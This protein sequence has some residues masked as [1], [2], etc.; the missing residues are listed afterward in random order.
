[1]GSLKKENGRNIV[2]TYPKDNMELCKS[3][4]TEMKEIHNSKSSKAL[5][6]FIATAAY[7]SPYANEV[8]ILRKYRDNVLLKTF[9]GRIMVSTY[10]LVSPPVAKIIS[11][12]ETLKSA[13]RRYIIRPVLKHISKN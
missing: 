5:Y 10:Y 3:C 6:C 11:K 13:T 12:S 7:D 8:K 4:Y 9:S 2:K 1:M